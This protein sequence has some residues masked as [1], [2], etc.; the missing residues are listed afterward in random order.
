MLVARHLDLAPARRHRQRH[1]F[2]A[3]ASL[4]PGPRRALL[5]AQGEAILFFARDAVLRGQR[6]RRLPHDLLGQ[7]AQE[8]VLVHAVHR[9]LVAHAVAPAR[10]GQEIGDPAHRLRPARQHDVG[11]TIA[12]GAVGEVDRLEAAAARHV[13]GEGG[14]FPRDAGTKGDLARDVGAAARLPG[15][16]DDRLVDL[17]GG[18]ATPPQGFRGRGRAELGG[19]QRRQAA[20]ELAD[21]GAHGAR[22]QYLPHAPCSPLEARAERASP[23]SR[24]VR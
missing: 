19:G 2:R 9:A 17:G 21:R 13:H 15:A 6:L 4:V 8:A 22:H 14:H 12:H 3:K 16:A 10:A 1:D 24:E 18:D 23:P 11:I 20:A 7:G 5:A